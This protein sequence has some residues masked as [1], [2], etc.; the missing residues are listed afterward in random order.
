MHDLL[1]SDL[2]LSVRARKC[3]TRLGVSTIGEL[4]SRSA[5]ELLSVRN[6]GVTSLNE[7]RD[8][9]RDRGLKLRGD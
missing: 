4:V 8:R 2:D 9:L 3:L 5:D 1:V 6:F 7:I